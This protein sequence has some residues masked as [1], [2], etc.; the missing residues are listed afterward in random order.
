MIVEPMAGDTPQENLN[1]V[2]RLFYC[3]STMI[4]TPASLSQEVGRG[5]RRTSRRKETPRSPR[6]R[7]LHANPPRRPNP[8][9]H[10][11]RSQ[12]VT[13]QILA[14]KPLK[15]PHRESRQSLGFAPQL[16]HPRGKSAS[17]SITPVASCSRPCR[18]RSSSHASSFLL[19]QQR[20]RHQHGR[21]HRMPPQPLPRPNQPRQRCRLPALTQQPMPPLPQ[22][23]PPHP[24]ET[25]P[26]T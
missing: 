17:A 20:N 12:G 2:G 18:T 8:L 11:P 21:P 15:P 23:A 19:P 3:A 16:S 25:A 5:P 14:E 24:P 7:R 6:S 26:Q 13:M 9:Q 10:D 4:C 1:P 22:S